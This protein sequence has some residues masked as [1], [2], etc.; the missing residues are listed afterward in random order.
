MDSQRLLLRVKNAS[1]EGLRRAGAYVRKVARHKVKRS[2]KSS[3]P[4]TPPN[5]RT[6]ALKRS[7]LFAVDKK[8]NTVY[9][10]SSHRLL[11][12]ALS[13]H[14]FGGKYKRERY[15]KRALMRPAL[16]QSSSKLP[17]LWD[18]IMK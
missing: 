6:G 17:K 5:T 3:A 4:G 12:T 8:K 14:E 15:P 7:L 10:G 11:G 16:Q 13:A 2:D 1:I 18:N 9:I